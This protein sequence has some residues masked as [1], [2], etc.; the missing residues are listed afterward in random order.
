MTS[1]LL[2]QYPKVTGCARSLRDLD[3][4]YCE[5][6]TGISRDRTKRKSLK[7]T[8]SP[9]EPTETDFKAACSHKSREDGRLTLIVAKSPLV[10]LVLP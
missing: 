2:R 1:S 5:K 10:D 4:S 6:P 8:E 3:V 9:Q 7:P